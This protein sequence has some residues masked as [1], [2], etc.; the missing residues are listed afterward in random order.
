MAGVDPR[1]PSRGTRLLCALLLAVVTFAVFSPALH[2]GF[3]DFDDD[4][5]LLD[6]PIVAN[7]LDATAVR[8]AFT[9]TRTGNWH[10]VTWL[11]HA[12]DVEWFGFDAAGHHGVSIAL[13]SLNAALL[14]LLLARFSG[15]L[16]PSILVAALFALHPL[17]AES[18]AWASE[19]KDV[20][21]GCFGLATLFAYG[22]WKKSGRRSSYA[23]ALV[24]FA[25]GC[26]SKSMLVTWPVLLVLFDLWPLRRPVR[27]LEKLPFAL[28][29]AATIV[30]AILTQH[31][32]GATAALR[33]I[34][35]IARIQ[36]A[37]AAGAWYT[38]ALLFPRDLA[39]FYPHPAVF[40]AVPWLPTA[41]G[42]VLLVAAS[43]LAFA[44]RRPMPFLGVGFGW[45]VVTLVPVIGLLQVGMQSHAD[46]YTYLPSIGFWIAMV[47]GVDALVARRAALRAPITVGAFAAV[48]IFGAATVRQVRFW[49]DTETLFEHTR[50]V[51]ERNWVALRALGNAYAADGEFERALEALAAE[52][53]LGL[54][55]AELE[56]RLGEL[57]FRLGRLDDALGYYRRAAELLPADGDLR[58][59]LAS[60]L[61]RL[62]DPEG[63]RAALAAA[64]AR[65]ADPARAAYTEGLV[66]A[67]LGD[68]SRS[69]AAYAEAVRI[70]P[71]YADAWNNLG[72]TE[73]ALGN[74]AAAVE[75]FERLV[76]LEPGNAAS[77]FNLA[78]ARER[79][80]DRAGA[81][82]AYRRALELGGDA[83]PAAA[84][85][86]R[87]EG[88]GDA[89]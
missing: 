10:P 79:A 48:G 42:V 47:F 26:M 6:N 58:L 67:F 44:L 29:S 13:H 46:R 34:P 76:A 77:S 54:G 59:D 15:R 53:R 25:L 12:L 55:D 71:G 63:A 83:T 64:R 41:L 62:G 18:V 89:R 60:V 52:E 35:P 43:G 16:W 7:G 11:S 40:G 39:V 8:M 31:G 21:S 88:Q 74:I 81:I 50:S 51:T 86:A 66:A 22:A 4:V 56:A 72:E 3:V 24:F 70:A 61:L 57:S 1:A 32:E 5:Y 45:F 73:L 65:G 82:E 2:A 78:L 23:L 68:P 38:G 33:L 17:R 36:N 37:F 20:L 84:A 19:R 14:L 80:H 9:S 28:V 69:R 27:W 75:A 87:L 49:H 85:L 30:I